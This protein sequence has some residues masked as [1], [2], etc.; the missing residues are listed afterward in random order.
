MAQLKQFRKFG[1]GNSEPTRSDRA[2]W[3]TAP[4]SQVGA[5]PREQMRDD[6]ISEKGS[7]VFELLERG[8]ARRKPGRRN[9]S[10]FARWGEQSSTAAHMR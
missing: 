4:R 3:N 6:C 7:K 10:V 8:A 9:L 1:E 5:E 2:L